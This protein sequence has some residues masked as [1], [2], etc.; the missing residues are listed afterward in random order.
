[1][2]KCHTSFSE[3]DYPD[4]RDL[5]SGAGYF[6]GLSEYSCHCMRKN[7][8]YSRE[9]DREY[10]GYFSHECE[11]IHIGGSMLKMALDRANI[12]QDEKEKILR[13]IEQLEAVSVDNSISRLSVSINDDKLGYVDLTPFIQVCDA[14]L[15]PPHW[16]RPPTYYI[17]CAKPYIPETTLRYNRG[18]TDEVNCVPYIKVNPVIGVCA[19]YAMRMAL[20]ILSPKAP[21]VP[22]LISEAINTA[23]SGGVERE[24]GIGWHPDEIHHFF[25]ISGY[26]VFRYSRSQLR[27]DNCGRL[28]S[29]IRMVPSIENIYAFVE[30]GLPVIIGVRNTKYLP[31]WGDGDEA[32][33]LVAIGHTLDSNGR[34]DGII[35][36]DESMY[37]Y[38][39]LK[40]PLMSGKTL[41]DVIFEAIAPVPREVTV[42]YQ[43]ARSLATQFFDLDEEDV[44]RPILTDSNQ[45][46]KWLGEGTRRRHLET[47]DLPSGVKEDYLSA[48][49]DR[50][51]WLFEIRKERDDKREYVGDVIVGAINPS[52]LGFIMPKQRIYGFRDNSRK[53]YV[54]YFDDTV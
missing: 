27:C 23:L 45:I 18:E 42:E 36:H 43:V 21:T 33:A 54:K 4:V 40:E 31:W 15:K 39:I 8:V 48:Y 10:R 12:P 26:G 3:C 28:V 24:S 29:D 49:M 13:I 30:S 50:Y 25:E 47:Y 17:T 9:W 44:I 38:Q 11:G 52:I 34:V 14:F 6:H 53:P 35:V 41:E 1:L 19:Q 20:M 51:V 22:E 46:K 37:P 7:S 32:H 5:L 16:M 2:R